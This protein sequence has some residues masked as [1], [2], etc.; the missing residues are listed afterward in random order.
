MFQNY[1]YWLFIYLLLFL[2]LFIYFFARRI[3]RCAQTFRTMKKTIP[4]KTTNCSRRMIS[5]RGIPLFHEKPG[6]LPGEDSSTSVT[7]T[8][9]GIQRI[10]LQP[11]NGQQYETLA[12]SFSSFLKRFGKQ[13]SGIFLIMLMLRHLSSEIHFFLKISNLWNA[14]PSDL[15]SE[16][17]VNVVKISWKHFTSPDYVLFF[18]LMTLVPTNLS[19]LNVVGL[20]I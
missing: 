10:Q 5:W 6:R 18:M 19:A 16:S 3:Q 4:D 15:K 13:F 1:C 8:T 14:L 17:N 20:I 2:F 9:T 7:H 11:N 12:R